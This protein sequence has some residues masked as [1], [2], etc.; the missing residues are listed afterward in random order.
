MVILNPEVR[1]LLNGEVMLV[2][3]LHLVNVLG[4]PSKLGSKVR[5]SGL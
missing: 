2:H 1:M 3:N 5:I 4:C